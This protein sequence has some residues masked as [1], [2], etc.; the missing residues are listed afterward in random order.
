MDA[1]KKSVENC[2]RENNFLPQFVYYANNA[3]TK[4]QNIDG[5]NIF[6]E[7]LLLRDYNLFNVIG[8]G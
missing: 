7:Y 4:L 8:I 6:L 5:F 2:G 3:G 1:L